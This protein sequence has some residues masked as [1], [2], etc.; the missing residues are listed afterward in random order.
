VIEK[1]SHF[2]S[3]NARSLAAL[4]QPGQLAHLLQQQ[5]QQQQSQRTQP[6]IPGASTLAQFVALAGN[7]HNK[8]DL[9]RFR[10][11]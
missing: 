7:L 11:H 1:F 6:L 2:L 5:Q 10:L 8:D 9:F 3:L 4:R